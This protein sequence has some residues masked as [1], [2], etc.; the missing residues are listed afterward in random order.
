MKRDVLY[1]C[2]RFVSG[3]VGVAWLVPVVYSKLPSLCSYYSVIQSL[4]KL[5]NSDMA[6]YLRETAQVCA[7]S[8]KQYDPTVVNDP[9]LM[10]M[11]SIINS[12]YREHSE[13]PIAKK[14]PLL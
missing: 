8:V 13:T 4:P 6:D 7:N 10:V 9:A 3:F 1:H 2:S 5:S 11:A 12:S 14:K